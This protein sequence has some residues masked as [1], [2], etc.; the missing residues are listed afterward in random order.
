MSKSSR[1]DAAKANRNINSSPINPPITERSTA[2]NKTETI[3][4]F[5]S[6]NKLTG[7]IGFVPATNSSGE[8]DVVDYKTRRVHST[9][10]GAIIKSA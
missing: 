7:F 8:N 4:R 3:N 10:R 5:E 6:L 9:V 1:V 2:S